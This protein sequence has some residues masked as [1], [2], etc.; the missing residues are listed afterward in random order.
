VG[1]ISRRDVRPWNYAGPVAK[2]YEMAQGAVEAI[3]GPTGGGKTTGSARRCLR[4]ARWQH[5]SPLDGIRKARI[6]CVCPTYRRAWDTVIPSYLKVMGQWGPLQGAKG[7]P[8][9]HIIDLTLNIDGQPAK[10]HVEVLFRA[11]QEMDLEVFVRGFETTAWWFPEMDTM[12]SEALISLA[13]NRVGRYPEPDD[14]P[15]DL[16]LPPAYAGVFG[17]ANAPVIGSWFHDRFYLKKRPGERLVRQPSGFS[18]RAE[19]LQNLRKIRPDYYAWLASTMDVY[20]VK[21]LIECKPGFTRF[22]QPVHPD[23]DDELHVAPGPLDADPTLQVIVACDQG[24]VPAAVF[25]QRRLNGQWR[26]LAEIAVM[27]GQMYAQEFGEQIRHVLDTRFARCR[28]AVIVFDPAAASAT[29]ASQFTNA[30]VVQAASGVE[31]QLAPSQDPLMRRGALDKTLKTMAGP[32]EPRILIDPACVN[33]IGG[34]VGGYHFERRG[35][36]LSPKPKKNRFANVVEAAQYGILW[37]EGMGGQ[38]G[39]ICAVGD[40]AYAAPQPLL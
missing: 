32:K 31:V 2:A 24:L 10:V 20:D 23:F 15:D 29:A 7:D 4:V 25:F 39:F 34:L 30:Q 16:T 26:A 37:G 35:D 5:P 33:L 17:D 12:D 36:V 38:G 9:S 22:G 18:P 1:E 40:D 27:E 11:V 28:Q 13:S 8:A 21:R 3:V 14:R 19:N 6:V